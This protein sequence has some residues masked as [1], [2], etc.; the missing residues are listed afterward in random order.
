VILPPARLIAP[1]RV[2]AGQSAVERLVRQ[3]Q[4][5]RE[6]LERALNVT[7]RPSAPALTPR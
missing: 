4:F 1:L 7:L 6:I 3:P 2:S 5:G